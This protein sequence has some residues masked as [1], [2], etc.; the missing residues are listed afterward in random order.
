MTKRTF[1]LNKADLYTRTK[2]DLGKEKT[3]L[4][5]EELCLAF[6]LFTSKMMRALCAFVVVLLHDEALTAAPSAGP[7]R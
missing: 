3:N 7:D 1:N 5:V 6:S 4:I 2:V